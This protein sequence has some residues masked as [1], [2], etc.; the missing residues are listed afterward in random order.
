MLFHATHRH[1][2]AT[3]PSHNPE[4]RALYNKALN[5]ASELG[6]KVIG[7]YADAPGHTAYLILEADTA[8]QIAQ[9]FDP[10]LEL[11]DAEIRPV[12]D[13]IELLKQMERRDK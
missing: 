7:S 6:I 5:S 8:L 2:H 11:G 9:F 13:T 1:T 12:T 3:C 10:I 4:K